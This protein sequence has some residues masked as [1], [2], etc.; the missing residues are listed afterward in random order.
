MKASYTVS[1]QTQRAG[2][3]PLSG[4]A[5][6]G[7]GSVGASKAFS[8]GREPLF[9]PRDFALLGNC[10]AIVHALRRPP[11]ARRAALLPQAPI[12]CRGSAPI[13]APARPESCRWSW[14]SRI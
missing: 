1:E 3:S 7:T 6:G 12:S 5:D 13:G 8:E 11:L 4:S 14:P 9:H 10:Q 2:A